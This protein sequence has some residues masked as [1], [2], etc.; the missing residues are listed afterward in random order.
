MLGTTIAHYKITAK[1]G[2]GGMGEV[3]R[4]TDTKLDREVAIKVLPV[5]MAKN[6]MRRQRFLREA[7][8]ASALNHPN[9]CV[10]HEISETADKRP[11]IVME[12]I[13]GPTLEN[14]MRLD[15]L[16]L[17]D[18]LEIA[19]QMADALDVAHTNGIVHRD[20]YL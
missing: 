12:H 16:L 10:I 11:F 3:Y 13:C 19:I 20:C 18:I 17:V 2:Q 14:R 6:P 5:A 7:Q 15:T 9:I 1:L 8:A 4:A